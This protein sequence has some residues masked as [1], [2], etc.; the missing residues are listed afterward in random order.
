MLGEVCGGLGEYFNTDPTLIRLLWSVIT[1]LSLGT[2]IVSC[3]IAWV[4]ISEKPADVS[5]PSAKE[6]PG[7]PPAD[8]LSE[9]VEAAFIALEC[10][11]SFAYARHSSLGLLVYLAHGLASLAFV[12]YLN[13]RCTRPY[14][15]SE[16]QRASLLSLYL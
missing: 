1:F 5:R 8:K 13:R 11:L 12:T 6:Q 2:G 4:V 3:V 9:V 10:N 14:R 16:A 15:A 7:P